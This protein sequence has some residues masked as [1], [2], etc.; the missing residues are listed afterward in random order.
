M[1]RAKERIIL[2]IDPGTIVLG[3]GLLYVSRNI[4]R[5]M[6]MGVVAL[7]RMEDHY[8]RLGHIYRRIVSI[9]DEFLPDEVALEEPFYGKNIQSML[10]LGRAQGVAMAAALSRDI[11]ITEYSPTKVK[12]SVTGTGQASKEQV[13]A[14]LRNTLKIKKED[15]QPHL[16]D[17][18]DALAVALCHY[19][20]SSNPLSTSD[21]SL[22]S[23]K[24]FVNANP[25]KIK[26]R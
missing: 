1:S 15:M 5:M 18:T 9:I 10:K 23:W 21:R 7:D 3:Y 20:Q 26:G 2:G 25:D 17:A 19:Y 4:P 8:Q 6:A 12:Q 14:I 22:S 13:A 24:A 16:L 11:P